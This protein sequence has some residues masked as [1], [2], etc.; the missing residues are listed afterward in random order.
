M[1]VE[2]DVA[3]ADLDDRRDDRGAVEVPA[4]SSG[5]ARSAACRGPG[6]T[7]IRSQTV[8]RS[9]VCWRMIWIVRRR[10]VGLLSGA[11]HRRRAPGRTAWREAGEPR[12]ASGART[13][14]RG[15]AS[16]ASGSSSRLGLSPWSS[17]LAMGVVRTPLTK[18]MEPK[19]PGAR[20]TACRRAIRLDLAIFGAES[21]AVAIAGIRAPPPTAVSARKAGIACPNRSCAARRMRA[22]AVSRAACRLLSMSPARWRATRGCRVWMRA[23]SIRDVER[24]TCTWR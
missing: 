5:R 1:P 23:S 17:R 9:L 20:T 6:G 10:L 14:R 18:G 7:S 4:P 16:P 13:D 8:I 3:A 12:P 2:R 24:A 19:T 15:T 11:P 21:C 22:Y